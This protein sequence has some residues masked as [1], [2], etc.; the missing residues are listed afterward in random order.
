MTALVKQA[1]ELFVETLPL[2][3]MSPDDHQFHHLYSLECKLYDCIRRMSES[4]LDDYRDR[5]SVIQ[6]EEGISY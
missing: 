2:E 1:V 4:E 6:P 3:G 5:V